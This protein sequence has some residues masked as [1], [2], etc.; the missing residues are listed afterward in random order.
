[1][2]STHLY[3]PFRKR[4]DAFTRELEDIE[5]GDVDALHHTRVASRRLRELLPLLELDRDVARTL[6]RRLRKATRQLGIVRELDVLMLL[7]HELKENS[8]YS[9]VAL[10]Q[11]GAMAAQAGAAARERL[12]AKLPRAKLERLA[13]KLDRV[14]K[15][16]ES[17]HAGS[18]RRG[19]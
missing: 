16:L 12:S 11:I 14:C 18:A 6:A 2:Y 13:R 8:Q 17:E 4:L 19:A 9:T 15:G 1:M 10:K 5:A 3:G 7:I